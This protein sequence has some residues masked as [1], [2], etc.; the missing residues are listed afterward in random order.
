[1]EIKKIKMTDLLEILSD[2]DRKTENE[3]VKKAI[4][5]IWHRAKECCN[6]DK[7]I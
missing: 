4:F 3:D 2:I 7:N 6:G 5:E 1:M